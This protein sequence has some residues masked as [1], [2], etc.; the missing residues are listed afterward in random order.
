MKRALILAA[1]LLAASPCAYA[2][3]TSPQVLR[4]VAASTGAVRY[5]TQT[6]PGYACGPLTPSSAAEQPPAPPASKPMKGQIYAFD[7]DGVRRFATTLPAGATN[8]RA[9]RYTFIE[10]CFACAADAPTFKR[11]RLNRAAFANE[12]R[13]ASLATG[14]EEALLRA[15]AHA[16]SAFVPDA[17]SRAGAQGLMQLMPA[18]AKRFGVRNTLDAQQNIF[19]GASYLAWLLRRYPGD[20]TRAVAAYNAGEGAVDKYKG[21]PPYAETRQYVKRVAQLLSAYRQP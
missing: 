21:I 19:G 6:V 17:I 1:G 8:V 13:A 15:V 20:L 2:N 16:E 9:I 5:A 12:F 18:T 14:V 4:C 10:S 7:V 11:S 3:D